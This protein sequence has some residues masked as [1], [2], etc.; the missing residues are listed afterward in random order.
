MNYGKAEP[1]DTKSK[2]TVAT[3]RQKKS[4]GEKFATIALYDAATAALAEVAGIDVLLVGDSLGMTV[5]GFDSTLPVTMDHMI[6]HVRAVSRGSRNALIIG[7][8]PFM[9]YATATQAMSNA[10]LL[11]Q[12]G[13]HM[14]KLEGGAWLVPTVQKL[15][16]RGI[17]VCAHLGL[18][19][20]S[21][22][23][24]GG[25]KI[26]GRDHAQAEQIR[27][28]AEAL[29]HAGADL[30]LFEC[31]PA[32]L[33]EEITNNLSVPTIGIGA[34]PGTDAQVLVVTDLLGMTGKPPKFAKDF[35]R[36]TGAIDEAF[37]KFASDV[38]AGHFP[39]PEHSF[40]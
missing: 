7:D 29:A 5:L 9:S 34:G 10:A 40:T 32:S 31:I 26:Q 30:L 24:F 25:Y 12:A 14:I 38:K 27:R 33:A 3:L 11:M 39:G 6:H 19:P 37:K 15:S 18:T 22:N 8:M 35:L 2:T 16:E 36:E 21:V 17:P 20:Q 28:D 1:A 23:K 13:A 4:S